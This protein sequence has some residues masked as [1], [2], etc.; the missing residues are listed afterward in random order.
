MEAQRKRLIQLLGMI[1]SAHDGEALNAARLAHK[2][3][4]GDFA[5]MLGSAPA[6][7]DDPDTFTRAQANA[8]AQLAF[9]AG[10]QEG[11][12]VGQQQTR[13]RRVSSWQRL[14]TDL[15]T[16]NLSEWERNFCKGFVARGFDTPTTKQQRVF[17]GMAQKFGYES[18]D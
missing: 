2:L 8:A 15:L 14:A 18:P 13:T 7:I 16:E 6:K 9:D 11:F 17:D 1:G 4:K 3:C 12:R 5:G 10:Y